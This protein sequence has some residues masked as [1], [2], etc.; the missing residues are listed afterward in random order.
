MRSLIYLQP[1]AYPTTRSHSI[2]ITKLVGAL[3]KQ[4]DVLFVVGSL[5][6][7]PEQ[8]R[9]DVRRIY[10]VEFGDRVR[11]AA[12]DSKWFHT[13]SFPFGLRKVLALAPK[14]ADF[15]TRSFPIARKLLRYRWLHGRRVFLE[16]HKKAGYLR[17]D[18][19][20]DSPYARTREVIEQVNQSLSFIRTVYS[21]ADCV[22]FLHRHSMDVARRDGA[23]RDSEH[24]WYGVRAPRQS[25]GRRQGFVHCGSILEGKMFHLLLD[26]LDRVQ[27]DVRVGIFGGE[28]S[29]IEALGR[30][31]SHRPC[32]PRLEFL[33]RLDHA[34]LQDRLLSYRYGIALKEAMK[35]VDYM[36][37][38]LTPIIPDIPSF[39][40][41]MDERHALFF[42][43]DDPASLAR[44]LDGAG[45][46][47]ADLAAARELFDRYSVD[48]RA[49]R[50]IAK[51]QSMP[52]G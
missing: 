24:I 13:F 11:V 9:D 40:E 51:L 15:Y 47:I 17:A 1:M 33:G 37:N 2:Q 38:G 45:G 34:A 36:E 28:A 5:T 16:T 31:A 22:F 21:R 4:I 48:R 43:S 20:A 14:D 32:W 3:G 35:V 8:V 49:E 10:G 50:V 29:V 23:V 19:V 42:R 6:V 25:G 41:V 52:D 44:C 12:V 27:T 7:R 26:A 18:P 39:R 30:T 46:H